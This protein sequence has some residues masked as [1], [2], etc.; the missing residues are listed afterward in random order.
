MYDKQKE[1]SLELTIFAYGN[2]ISTFTDSFN[3]SIGFIK[4]SEAF[5]HDHYQL[6]AGLKRIVLSG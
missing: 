6:G 1:N 3:R 5:I 4:H 2:Y